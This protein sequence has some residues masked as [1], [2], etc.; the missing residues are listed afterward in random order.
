ML[1]R[2][3]KFAVVAVLIASLSSASGWSAPPPQKNGGFRGVTNSGSGGS[4]GGSGSGS[5]ANSGN[6][7]V[8]KNLTN[9]NLT[10]S[11]ALG[12]TGAGNNNTVRSFKGTTGI[13]TTG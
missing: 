1:K 2:T 11:N 4:G 5:G 8:H 12:T 9:K 7:L 3:G 10:N 6:T 13:G